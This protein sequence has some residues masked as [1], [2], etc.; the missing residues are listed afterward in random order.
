MADPSEHLLVESAEELPD[1]ELDLQLEAV[2]G[3]APLSLPHRSQH[4]SLCLAEWRDNEDDI[5]SLSSMIP[6][7]GF[8]TLQVID[9]S[10]VEGV[11]TGQIVVHDGHCFVSAKVDARYLVELKKRSWGMYSLIQIRSTSGLHTE[12]VLVS[13][14]V[15]L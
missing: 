5:G 12:L 13:I 11:P 3:D 4:L 6:P 1:P 9:I 7:C 10:M 14:M 8:L 15:Y 2:Q